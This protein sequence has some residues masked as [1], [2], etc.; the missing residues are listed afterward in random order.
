MNNAAIARISVALWDARKKDYTYFTVP[1][2][3][4]VTLDSCSSLTK[5][6]E[7]ILKESCF[8]DLRYEVDVAPIT[9]GAKRYIDR[10]ISGKTYRVRFREMCKVI[11][12]AD[13][14]KLL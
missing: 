9:F 14:S 4:Q 1:V 10:K 13:I 12:Q 3:D 7:I 11:E 8:G 5:G 6:M 2:Y